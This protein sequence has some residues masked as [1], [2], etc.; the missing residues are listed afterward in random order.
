[1]AVPWKPS[2]KNIKKR[3]TRNRIHIRVEILARR[4]L[5]MVESMHFDARSNL[6]IINLSGTYFTLKCKRFSVS[7]YFLHYS[8]E[9]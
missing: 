7:I 9:I 4:R 6:L 8:F 3:I 2:K 1:M 5:L